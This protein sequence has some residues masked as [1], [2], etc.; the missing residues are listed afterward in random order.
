LISAKAEA[1]GSVKVQNDA[2]GHQLRFSRRMLRAWQLYLLPVWS[3]FGLSRTGLS[4]KPISFWLEHSG[5][6]PTCPRKRSTAIG[7]RAVPYLMAELRRKESSFVG[8]INSLCDNLPASFAQ[9]LPRLNNTPPMRQAARLALEKIG[10]PA[11]PALIAGLN[12]RN[13]TVRFFCAL[14]L[15]KFRPVANDTVTAL[16]GKLGDPDRE[17]RLP[18]WSAWQNGCS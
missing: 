14:T 10:Q 5:T 8:R 1:V 7:E 11:I 9:A 3:G 6:A 17:V 13:Q 12:D 18:S 16:I 4:G 2:A 15:G